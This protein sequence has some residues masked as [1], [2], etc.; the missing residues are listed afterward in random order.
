MK[1]YR[2]EYLSALQVFLLK[3]AKDH[4]LRKKGIPG[5][6]IFKKSKSISPPERSETDT[7]LQKRNSAEKDIVLL[8]LQCNSQKIPDFL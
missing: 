3:A 1:N 8:H 2:K 7:V 5:L 6:C 4:E